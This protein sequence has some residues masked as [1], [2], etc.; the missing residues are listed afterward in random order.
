MPPNDGSARLI[1][2]RPRT[3]RV[4]IDRINADRITIHVR[5]HSA[6]DQ[7]EGAVNFVRRPLEQGH[8]LRGPVGVT[9]LDAPLPIQHDDVLD[10]RDRFARPPR[11]LPR[12][13]PLGSQPLDPPRPGAGPARLTQI[14]NDQL[15]R[16]EGSG[17]QLNC[18]ALAEIQALFQASGPPPGDLVVDRA[19]PRQPQENPEQDQGRL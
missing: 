10:R 17:V 13:D 3:R 18:L 16:I 9:G 2:Q 8:P 7:F 1:N 4:V 11:E 14:R 6:L 5:F 12:V 15:D 19:A